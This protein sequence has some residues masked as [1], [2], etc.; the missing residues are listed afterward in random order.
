MRSAQL[1][2]QASRLTYL[3]FRARRDGRQPPW[4]LL[5]WRESNISPSSALPLPR[6]RRNR[7]N[8]RFWC[9]L[10]PHPLPF[11]LECCPVLLQMARHMLSCEAR[12]VHSG[13]DLPRERRVD[14][15]SAQRFLELLL[16]V[17]SPHDA[18]TL[19]GLHGRGDGVGRGWAADDPARETLNASQAVPACAGG[20][21]AVCG[22]GVGAVGE[23]CV[24]AVVRH[25]LS[26]RGD[27]GLSGRPRHTSSGD[28]ARRRV[29]R[30]AFERRQ[31]PA[32]V[33]QRDMQRA[34]AGTPNRLR[35]RR[36][37][38]RWREASNRLR[39]VLGPCSGRGV[40]AGGLSYVSAPF[41]H[42]PHL[43]GGEWAGYRRTRRYARVGRRRRPHRPPARAPA[44]RQAR[45]RTGSRRGRVACIRTRGRHRPLEREKL[46]PRERLWCPSCRDGR[47]FWA[48]F[49]KQWGTGA[50][51]RVRGGVHDESARLR[52]H[53]GRGRGRWCRGVSGGLMGARSRGG[54]GLHG[55]LTVVASATVEWAAYTGWERQLCCACC[56]AGSVVGS[57]RV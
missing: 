30:D 48:D 20:R 8:R 33:A 11:L 7:R 57:W 21:R 35:R 39:R 34:C 38:R 18:R 4:C 52:R 23:G 32:A 14:P 51:V 29:W 26:C 15:Q 43:G 53:R 6:A 17:A 56:G 28:W 31:E 36:G 45:H 54:W 9:E 1:F 42:L 16:K 27:G 50:G 2:T 46:G 44:R 13:Q 41:G 22:R 10:S 55:C 24:R 37:V 47:V 3:V 40:P 49:Q 12:D 5:P 25:V 19:P